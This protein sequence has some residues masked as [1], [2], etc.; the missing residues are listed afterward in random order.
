[1]CINMKEMGV[2]TA[3]HYPVPLHFQPALHHL[4]LQEGSLPV[5]EN[6][7]KRVVSLPMH[8]YLSES[9]QDSI[10]DKIKKSI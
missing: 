6:V 4:G 1:F 5:S 3:I 8:P 9:E 7:A 10:V 2:P